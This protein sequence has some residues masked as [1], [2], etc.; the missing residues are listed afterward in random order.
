MLSYTCDPGIGSVKY[1][2]LAL[3][4]LSVLFKLGSLGTMIGGLL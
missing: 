2:R 4:P 1:Y 3:L